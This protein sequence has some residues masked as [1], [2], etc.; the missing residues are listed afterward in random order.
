M[1]NIFWYFICGGLSLAV[2]VL[3]FCISRKDGLFTF[4][5]TTGKETTYWNWLKKKIALKRGIAFLIVFLL[6]ITTALCVCTYDSKPWYL[7]GS[8]II[9]ILGFFIARSIYKKYHAKEKP[10]VLKQG[11][12]ENANSN[13]EATPMS[14]GKFFP[15]WLRV[16]ACT[17]LVLGILYFINPWHS[18]E[19]LLSHFGIPYTLINKKSFTTGQ[20]VDIYVSEHGTIWFEGNPRNDFWEIRVTSASYPEYWYIMRNGSI[21]SFSKTNTIPSGIWNVVSL[22]DVAD[23]KIVAK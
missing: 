16:L 14:W 21:T 9:L 2:L 22:R 6:M 11:T 10:S 15:K 19:R 12:E 13:T 20:S 1:D 23:F 3:L 7:V 18:R 8:F 5:D 17:A 4:T